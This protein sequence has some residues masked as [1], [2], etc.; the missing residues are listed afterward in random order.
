MSRRL[1]DSLQTGLAFGSQLVSQEFK[2]GAER[3]SV[4]GVC[5]DD[6]FFLGALTGISVIWVTRSTS[7]QEQ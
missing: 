7:L 6:G 1:K 4:H 2:M 3:C 5:T